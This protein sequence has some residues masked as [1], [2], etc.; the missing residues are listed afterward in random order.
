MSEKSIPLH[1]EKGLNPRLTYCPRCHADGQELILVG[2]NDGVYECLA[3]GQTVIGRSDHCP[4]CPSR[5]HARRLRTLEEGERLPGSLCATCE[6]ETQEHAALVE[7]GGVYWKCADC[8]RS[9]VIRSSPFAQAVR[10]SQ[11][12]ASVGLAANFYTEAVHDKAAPSPAKPARNVLVGG[13][14]VYAPVGVEFTKADC[15]ACGPQP[16][17]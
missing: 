6:K 15:P 11:Q 10:A 3:C 12:K 14:K 16:A 1:P 9:G 7:A 2:A 13:P 5:W 4:A 17:S 8:T